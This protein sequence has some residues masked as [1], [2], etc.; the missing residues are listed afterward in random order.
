MKLVDNRL[1]LGQNLVNVTSV[2][3]IPWPL[4]QDEDACMY[5]RNVP[6]TSPTKPGVMKLPVVLPIVG[7][8]DAIL[9][10][11]EQ[12]LIVIVQVFAIRGSS[13]LDVVAKEPEFISG[14]EGEVIV[15]KQ[16]GHSSNV[17][18][19]VGGDP[20]I[21]DWLMTSVE[22]ERCVDG[23]KGEMIGP[24]DIGPIT[25]TRGKIAHQR[26]D[27]H[28]ISGEPGVLDATSVRIDNDVL[29]NQF[30]VVRFMLD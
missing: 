3:A 18:K 20:S 21:N 26:P 12:Q 9:L 29:G 4:A 24:C 27:W 13:R 11:G 6:C 25:L 17:S 14:F 15:E 16:T 2:P 8:K 19:G 28:A 7:N 30:V 1:L 5:P 23:I 10:G 22:R